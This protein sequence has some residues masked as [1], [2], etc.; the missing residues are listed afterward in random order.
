VKKAVKYSLQ[1]IG[2]LDSLVSA[3]DRVLVKPNLIAPYHYRTGATT[4]LFVIRALCALAKEA[5]A[6]K[7]TIADSSAVGHKTD[8]VFAVTG[9]K[10]LS[11]KIG[12]ELIDFK[13]A[14]TVYMGIAN[15]KIFKRIK[16][17]EA[18]MEAD[19]IINAPVMKTHDVFPATL[20]LKNMKGVLQEKDKKRFHKWGLAQSIVDLNK[21]VLPQ[22]T[23]LDGTVCMEGMG[24]THG[25]PVNL[26]IIIS[27]FDTVAGDS[28]AA[29]V[30]GIAPSKIEYV[31]LAFEQGL[32]CA[33]LSRIQ[34]LGL[35]I[36]KV[37]RPFRQV[38]LDFEFW[39]EKGIEIYEKGACSGCRN[40]VA[41]F[42][43]DLQKNKDE[44]QLLKGYALIFGQ[45]I[46]LPDKYEGRLVNIGLCTRKFR[47]KDEYIPG[48]PP[49]PEE[50]LAFFE[51]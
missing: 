47:G 42:I 44:L 35:A 8:E 24:P 13:K 14:K 6:R 28:V 29:T 9:L 36:E 10:E 18:F 12:V 7:I 5:G 34:V 11:T 37:K 30:M 39:R 4:N 51:K 22:L 1:L 20:G 27:S 25:T 19:V 23:V 16:I 41:A 21:L 2:G 3:G 31:K 40:T 49:H 38:K 48:C 46:K 33:D 26:G 50:L 32:G 17:P 15:G 45:N 43:A